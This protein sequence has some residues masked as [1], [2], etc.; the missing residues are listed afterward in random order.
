VPGSQTAP[1]LLVVD[2]NQDAREMYCTYLEFLG[3]RCLQCDS[4]EQ[5]IA[6]AKARTPA[7]ILMDATMPG[8]DGWEATRRLK[9]DPKTAAI[10][11]A[12][13]TAHAFEEYRLKAASVGADAFLAKPILP[14]QLA[15]EIRRIL[16]M[17]G[18]RQS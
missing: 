7:L 6:E 1:L 9:A 12:M 14:D 2:D 11:I 17:P 18:K 16:K 3:F 10:P 5:A 13:L 8:L 15:V 4:A